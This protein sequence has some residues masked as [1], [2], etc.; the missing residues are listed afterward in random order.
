[1]I[2]LCYFQA[3]CYHGQTLLAGDK[4]GEAIRSLQEAEK[5]KQ[6]I[7]PST[8][9]HISAIYDVL[10]GILVDIF[11]ILREGLLHSLGYMPYMHG[12][13]YLCLKGTIH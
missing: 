5:C 9:D 8:N 11:Y 13:G 1:M 2:Y 12:I 3:H 4:C 6:M 7:N 10:L